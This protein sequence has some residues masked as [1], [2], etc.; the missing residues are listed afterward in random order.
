MQGKFPGVSSLDMPWL[1]LLNDAG[2]IRVDQEKAVIEDKYLDT[3]N[4]LLM[5]IRNPI[6]ADIFSAYDRKK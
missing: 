1:V 4:S 5:G 2:L 6:G 3:V